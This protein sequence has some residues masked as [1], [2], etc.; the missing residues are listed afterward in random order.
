MNRWKLT[1]EYDG[2]AFCGWQRQLGDPTIQQTIEEAIEKFCGE[3]AGLHVAGRTDAGVHARAQVA[4]VDIAK[5]FD[6]DTVRDAINHYLR[7][8]RIAVLSAEEVDE[9]FHAR[10]NAVERS[11]K[12]TI[13]NRTAPLALDAE[14][15]WHVRRPLDIP[16]MQAAADMLIGNHDFSTFR[17]RNCQ[18]K[19]PVKTLDRLDIARDGERIVFSTSAR[20]FLYHQV[21]NMVGT[22]ALVGSGQWSLSDFAN[23]FAA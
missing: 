11:Y 22:L 12:Y 16:A 3:T 23:A 17:A 21:R 4:H 20:S 13:A 14:R 6:G 15:A 2:G 1:I 9:T 18:A 19:S 8:H 7:P 5:A 10:F